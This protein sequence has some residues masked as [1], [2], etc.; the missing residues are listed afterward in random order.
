MLYPVYKNV[1]SPIF[2]ALQPLSQFGVG[3][4]ITCFHAYNGHLNAFFRPQPIYAASCFLHDAAFFIY[5]DDAV[6]VMSRPIPLLKKLHI[7]NLKIIKKCY[8][9]LQ[10]RSY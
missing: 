1:I 5:P 2:S 6:L 4:V 3:G 10:K 9:E 8:Y 7:I